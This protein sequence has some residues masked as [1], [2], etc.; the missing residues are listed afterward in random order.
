[1]D[2]TCLRT[3]SGDEA[4]LKS[5]QKLAE[6]SGHPHGRWASPQVVDGQP[7]SGSQAALLGRPAFCASLRQPSTQAALR[8]Q[9]TW[10]ASKLS[11]RQCAN[12]F[13][14]SGHANSH[15]SS[16]AS[17][18]RI[19]DLNPSGRLAHGSE[20]WA[21]PATETRNP[22][23]TTNDFLQQINGADRMRQILTIRSQRY[24][25]AWFC[26]L[27]K[28]PRFFTKEVILRGKLARGFLANRIDAGARSSTDA[29]K[30]SMKVGEWTYNYVNY[31][32]KV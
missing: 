13:G 32:P 6:R 16:H 27:D 14:T 3:S 20:D 19:S 18:A 7:Q 5:F 28:G 10:T 4:L 11:L 1:M 26:R 12:S 17:G 9:S 24:L 15:A 2:S 22:M 23:V 25:A 8:C 21:P 30:C 31:I 29:K